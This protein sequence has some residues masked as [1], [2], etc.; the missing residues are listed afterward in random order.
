MSLVELFRL[1][2]DQRKYKEAAKYFKMALYDLEKTNAQNES[3]AEFFKLLEEYAV[4]LN[5]IGN[6]EEAKNAKE[7]ALETKKIAKFS[8]TDRTPYGSYCH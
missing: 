8:I 7:R 1:N 6:F 2:L 5:A 4:A 3:P